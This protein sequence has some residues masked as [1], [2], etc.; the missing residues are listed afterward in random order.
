MLFQAQNAKTQGP[1]FQ[2]VLLT[3]LASEL[4]KKGFAAVLGCPALP[5]QLVPEGG[6]GPPLQDAP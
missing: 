6:E 5:S 2:A 4:P 3:E 1:S